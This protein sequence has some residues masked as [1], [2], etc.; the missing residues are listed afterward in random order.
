MARRHFAIGDDGHAGVHA[1]ADAEVHA[2]CLRNGGGPAAAQRHQLERRHAGLPRIGVAGMRIAEQHD[3]AV[4]ERAGQQAAAAGGG[5]GEQREFV[6]LQQFDVFDVGGQRG[7]RLGAVGVGVGP[8]RDAAA[9]HGELPLLGEDARGGHGARHRFVLRL[10]GRA[11]HADEV[12]EPQ[13]REFGQQRG[14]GIASLRGFLLQ[15][16]AQ[17]RGHR[18][19]HDFGRQR[20]FLRAQLPV[21]DFRG[22]R[23][24]H[25]GRARQAFEEHQAPGIEVGADARRFAAQLFGRAVGRRSQAFLG[26]GERGE[27]Q[28]G[29]LG[30]DGADAEVEHLRMGHGAGERH[31][32]VVGLEVAVH[33]AGGM[34]AVECVQHLGHE[35]AGLG[36]RQRA[37]AAD[38]AGEGFARHVFEDAVDAIA[39]LALVQQ[40]HDVRMVQRGAEPGF[41]VKARHAAVARLQ[42]HDL[43]RDLCAGASLARA[44]HRAV[45]AG[46]QRLLEVVAGNLQRGWCELRRCGLS[47]V[48]GGILH[49]SLVCGSL[50]VLLKALG[51][52]STIRRTG[53]ATP[54]VTLAEGKDFPHGLP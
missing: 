18:V 5:L 6:A 49:F 16:L 8:D 35:A 38:E 15:R 24:L 4:A 37:L 43:D 29:A 33:D 19:L 23:T 12:F 25:G 14:R 50:A 3:H 10:P 54:I 27:L 9:Q 44:V 39:L 45:A 48:G 36:G 32:H 28:A 52:R 26:H 1:H 47:G 30:N 51:R 22:R 7:T 17:Q 42:L 13:A 46:A 20:D 40:L 34:R 21:Q 31:H 53:A 11:Q 41:A 2:V